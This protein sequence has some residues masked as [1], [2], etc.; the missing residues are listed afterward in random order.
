MDHT[1]SIGFRCPF[2]G[3]AVRLVYAYIVGVDLFPPCPLLPEGLRPRPAGRFILWLKQVADE[4]YANYWGTI[5]MQRY[6][7]WAFIIWF[8]GVLGIV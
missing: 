6:N 4:R 2:E 3:I 1:G 8:S 7:M 5:N